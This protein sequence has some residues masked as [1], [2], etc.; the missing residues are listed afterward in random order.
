MKLYELAYACRL[1]GEDD[2]AYCK[3]RKTLGQTSALAS[4]EQ[5]K[6]LLKFLNKWGCRIAEYDV[7]ELT[8]E[9]QKWWAEDNC[10]L[11]DKNIRALDDSERDQIGK[12]YEE[13]LQLGAG[14]HFQDTAA[15]KT[16]H[17][18]RPDTLPMWDAKI[19]EWFT[20]EVGKTYSDFVRHVAEEI[21]E[22]EEDVRRLDHSLNHVP[23]LVHS[24]A[25]SASLVKLADEYYWVTKTLGYT[26][27]TREQAEKWLK[28][29]P[30]NRS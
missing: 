23:Q 8:K 22:L 9:L 12:S 21:S 24:R 20:D 29:M 28:W 15:A 19:K 13:L 3:M 17:V 4:P 7:D 25:D 6:E 27:P 26:V 14:L 11:P 5:W 2:A 1:Y 16:L 18:L 30:D 10:K